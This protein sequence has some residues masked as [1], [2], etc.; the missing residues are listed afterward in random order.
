MIAALTTGLLFG[1]AAGLAPGPLLTLVISHAMRY[2]I[3]EGIKVAMSP[4]VTDLPIILS[5]IWLV[6]FFQ[7]TP[8]P[9]G[10]LALV[11]AGYLCLLAWKSARVSVADC[12]TAP[13][14]AKSLLKGAIVNLLNPHPW[15]FWLT[16]GTPM[17]LQGWKTTPWT[18]VAWISGFYITLVGSKVAL[19]ALTGRSRA[20][21]SSRSYQWANRILSLILLL[22]AVILFRDGL[23]LLQ[24]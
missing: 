2:G 18:S 15:L 6:S 12:E 10:L 19:A 9:M 24:G 1:L 8:W 17:L 21:L 22:F 13:E 5:A 14:N 11:G 23:K 16:V 20:Y 4:F 7:K 3:G